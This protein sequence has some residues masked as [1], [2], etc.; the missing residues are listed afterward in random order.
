LPTPCD[1]DADRERGLLNCSA[2]WGGCQLS[3]ALLLGA[4]GCPTRYAVCTKIVA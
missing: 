2:C 1:L 4:K 3:S